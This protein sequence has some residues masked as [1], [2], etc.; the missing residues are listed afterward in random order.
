[1]NRWPTLL[2][3]TLAVAAIVFLAI[4]E[5]LTRSAR[6]GDLI[7]TERT[8]LPLNPAKIRKI[9][10]ISGDTDVE[11]RRSGDGWL[12]GEKSKDRADSDAIDR[13]LTTAAQMQFFDRIEAREV[14]NDKDLSDF[15][16]RRPK[17]RIE[18]EGD[19]TL[20]L[21]LGK[22]GASEDRLY[23]RTSAS[24]DVFL[25]SDQI[26]RQAFRPAG[27]FRDR[28]LTRLSPD[29]V[30]RLV[31]RRA[32]GDLEFVRDAQGWQI[33]RPL[34]VPADDLKVAQFLS[35][36]LGLRVSEY[37]AD[38][39][40]DLSVYGLTEGRD[41]IT[42][43]ADGEERPQTL[44][45]GRDK[46][47][48]LFGQF[49]ARDSI[50]RLPAEVAE[51]LKVTPDLLRDRRLLPLNLDAVDR[52]RIAAADRTFL[53]QRIGDG[54]EVR[55]GR[56]VFPA[57]DAAV[58]ALADG[59]STAQVGEFTSAT[60]DRLAAAGLDH[61]PLVL[62]FLSVLSENTPEERAG[63]HEIGS[64][65]LGKTDGTTT[66]ARVGGSPELVRVDASLL[67]VIPT[68]SAAWK[69]LRN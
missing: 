26:L 55:D 60:A 36:V 53:L 58:R 14:P 33:T 2:L 68:D 46:N 61:P 52:I 30:G 22:D 11:F 67:S 5:P 4:Y 66:F 8:V 49:T 43:Y 31:I 23:V 13:L 54:W 57:S 27:E 42:F 6:E 51:L 10:V 48:V 39:F 56:D 21:F 59:V 40:G 50:Y 64:L 28:R 37:V 62:T 19:K 15:G 38:D 29:R 12:L 47:G 1:M 16:L 20:T 3:A 69:S 9:R 25:V 63:E 45:L 44:R 32:D 35:Y 7:R 17:R 65:A 34:H 41:E 24:R 18:F